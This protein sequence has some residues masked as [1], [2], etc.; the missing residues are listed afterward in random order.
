MHCSKIAAMHSRDGPP[1]PPPTVR[2]AYFNEGLIGE[3]KKKIL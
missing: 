2:R 1:T 3:I